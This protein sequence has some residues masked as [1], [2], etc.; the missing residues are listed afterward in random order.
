M[1]TLLSNFQEPKQENFQQDPANAET[2]VGSEPGTVSN[3][4]DGLSEPP[5][6]QTPEPTSLQGLSLPDPIKFRQQFDIKETG[7][8]GEVTL[9]K[10]EKQKD[11]IAFGDYT[12]VTKKSFV[13]PKES[14]A[15]V[16]KTL[17]VEDLEIKPD[18]KF[19]VSKELNTIDNRLESGFLRIGERLLR[20]PAFMNRQMFVLERPFIS[21][22]TRNAY[23]NMSAKKQDEF[24]QER[25]ST[26]MS[27]SGF[28]IFA[29][30]K[31]TQEQAKELDEKAAKLESNLVEYEDGIVEAFGKG[32]ITEATTRAL[33]ESIGAIPSVIQAFIPYVG[34][35]S[36]FAGSAARASDDAIEQGKEIDFKH[37]AYANTRGASDAL[38][39]I[40]TK[41][42]GSKYFK[43]LSGKS[44]PVIKISVEKVALSSLLK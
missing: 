43:A 8:Q 44:K 39:E 16:P 22:E 26:T 5:K 25:Y 11:K 12:N 10:D 31:F 3:L 1:E 28:G 30:A 27:P 15:T 34:I 24:I 40:V 38:L 42:I 4:E 19:D 29:L 2:S 41:R 33:T 36:I 17:L 35:P 21:E 18:E 9:S 6:T 32:K 20:V 23:D 7:E 14:T 13:Q 37:L